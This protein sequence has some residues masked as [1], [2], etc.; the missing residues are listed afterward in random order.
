MLT[1]HAYHL[2]PMSYFS[3]RQGRS[4][5]AF[6]L[7]ELLVVIGI[8]AVLMGIL[9]PALGKA[10]S[11]AR[12]TQCM[13]NLRQWGVGFAMY[14]NQ[15]KGSLPDDG[16]DGNNPANSIR[17]WDAA[18]MWFN[19]I[20]RMV[21]NKSYDDL[22]KADLAGTAR[23]PIDGDN[24]LFVCPSASRAI[25]AP[26]DQLYDDGYFRMFGDTLSPAATGE[27]RKTFLCYV[28]NSKLM[29]NSNPTLK[30]SKLRPSSHFVLMVEKRMRPGE[31]SPLDSAAYGTSLARIKADRKRF[32]ARHRNGGF[33]LF[34]DGHVGWFSNA[35]VN[36][37][38]QVSPF[39]DY[40]YP[41]KVMWNPYGAAD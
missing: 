1:L 30:I 37:P 35:E 27:A 41:N 33:L 5:Q 40:N 34:A 39:V 26:T 6:T 38:R 8:I 15:S 32:T 19:A 16:E 31:V 18:W 13:N 23:L 21:N 9:V 11:S 20:P 28:L 22:Q 7:V 4:H 14:V 29:S 24:S 36:V 10:R 2:P 17:Y 12:E 3:A 25:G